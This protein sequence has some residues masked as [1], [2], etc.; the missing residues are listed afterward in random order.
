MNET[1]M[2]ETSLS[3]DVLSMHLGGVS[4][5]IYSNIVHR[6]DPTVAT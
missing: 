4:G 6:A 2:S 3:A 5:C 1:S